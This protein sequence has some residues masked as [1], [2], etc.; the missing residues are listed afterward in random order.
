MMTATEI[1]VLALAA[2]A[3]V[4]VW[5]QGSIFNKA[6]KLVDDHDALGTG[7]FWARLL[8]CWYCLSY[9]IPAIILAAAGLARRI[10]PDAWY[11]V[12]ALAATRIVV[13]IN[14]LVPARMRH[15]YEPEAERAAQEPTE[16][17]DIDHT[18]EG[19]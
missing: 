2:S 4:D 11:A 17:L 1:G 7:P 16:F 10:W 9:W 13:L 6:R 3:A 18:A 19:E 12:E 5:R 15:E 14:G 8:N